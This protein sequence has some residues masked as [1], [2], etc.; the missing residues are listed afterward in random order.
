MEKIKI[1]GFRK[2]QREV[3]RNKLLEIARQV[4]D[5]AELERKFNKENLKLLKDIDIIKLLINL[6]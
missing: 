1:E 3:I 4:L 2:E 6:L 5:L